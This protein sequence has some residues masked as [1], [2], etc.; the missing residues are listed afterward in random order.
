M[1]YSIAFKTFV[2]QGLNKYFIGT[3]YPN[4][5]ILFIGKESAI[6]TDD[7][8]AMKW[9]S[10]NAESWLKH[11]EGNTCEIL[12]YPVNEDNS[13]KKGW[14]KN[15]WSKYQKLTDYIFEKKSESFKIDFLKN[16]FT[17]EINDDP[18]KNTTNANKSGL[19]GR[20]LLFKNSDFIQQ[21]PVVV[22]ACS[23]YIKNNDELREIDEIFSVTY[24]GD[25]KGKHLFS[26]G[27]WFFTHHNKGNSKLVI[28]TRQLSANVENTMLQEI[29]KIIR[30]HLNKSEGKLLT[31]SF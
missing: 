26:Q 21:F 23:D 7:K 5:K 24:D 16:V 17:S 13:L 8:E 10:S 4:A 2:E 25:E 15:T 11:I 6:S 14:G 1:N 3:G 29:G 22:L 20:K 27:N 30:E 9:Y 18:N 31:K 28:H 12:E 19:N